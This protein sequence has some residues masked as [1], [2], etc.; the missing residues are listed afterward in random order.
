MKIEMKETTK[1]RTQV[2]LV[3]TFEAGKKYDVADTVGKSL[4]GSDKA[5]EIKRGPKP[6]TVEVEE[7]KIVEPE[8]KKEAPKTEKK[9]AKKSSK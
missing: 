6:K 5:T 9:K 8:V 2:D 4:I 7:K 3:E 1:Y